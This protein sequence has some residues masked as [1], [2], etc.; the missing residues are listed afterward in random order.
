MFVRLVSLTLKLAS[1]LH[2]INVYIPPEIR[3]PAW[4][5]AL[6]VS[7]PCGYWKFNGYFGQK[8]SKTPYNFHSSCTPQ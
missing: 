6:K 4:A 3:K 5:L 1:P 2:K 7:F 8:L